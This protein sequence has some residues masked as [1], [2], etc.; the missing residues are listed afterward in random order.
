MPEARLVSSATRPREVLLSDDPPEARTQR[1]PR[2]A[3]GG[4]AP[5]SYPEWDYRIGAYHTD[6]VHLHVLPCELGPAAWV[7]QTLD[8]HRSLLQQIGRQFELLR[9]RRTRLRKQVDGDEIDLE[10]YLDSRA[11]F[12][13]GLPLGQRLYQTQRRIHCDLAI[14]L[15]VDVRGPKRSGPRA[16]YL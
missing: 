12:A 5:L 8:R 15:L 13:A 6:A 3:G 4:G 7:E 11:D 10:A 1:L 14:M 2:A 16:F 9:A